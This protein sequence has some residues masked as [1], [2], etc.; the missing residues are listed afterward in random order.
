M[1]GVEPPIWS[2]LYN[3]GGRVVFASCRYFITSVTRFGEISPLWQNFKVF[4][5]SLK[6]LLYNSQNSEP[7]WANL[8]TLDKLSLLLL[9]QY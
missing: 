2:V 3:S 8:M 9:T 6:V 4:V 1:Q 7:N 5:F